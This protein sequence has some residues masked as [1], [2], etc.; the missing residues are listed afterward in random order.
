MKSLIQKYK[1][2][3]EEKERIDELFTQTAHKVQQ[4]EPKRIAEKSQNHKPVKNSKLIS[5]MIDRKNGSTQQSQENKQCNTYSTHSAEIKLQSTPAT[6]YRISQNAKIIRLD[7][8][9]YMPTNTISLINNGMPTSI[10]INASNNN[11]NTT[12]RI[13][14]LLNA[15]QQPIF[16]GSS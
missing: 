14:K 6:A 8:R 15:Q 4:T 3:K 5:Q 9:V 7:S 11:Q 10:Q 13:V 16:N 12:F 2:Q 1:K